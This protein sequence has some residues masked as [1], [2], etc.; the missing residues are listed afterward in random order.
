MTLRH[1]AAAALALG[2]GASALAQAPPGAPPGT[3]NAAP[4]TSGAFTGDDSL[5]AGNAG[6]MSGEI[7]TGFQSIIYKRI[8]VSEAS[9]LWGITGNGTFVDSARD[10]EDLEWFFTVDPFVASLATATPT[11]GTVAN[12]T[13][14]VAGSIYRG[15]GYRGGTSENHDL[16]LS[17]IDG[18]R[19]VLDPGEYYVSVWYDAG[20]AS[21]LWEWTELSTT[22]TFSDIFW[23]SSLHQVGEFDLIA[24]QNTGGGLQMQTGDLAF[25]VW[26]TPVNNCPADLTG[27]GVVDGADLGALLGDWGGSASDLTGD[28][29]V[30]GADLGALLGAWGACA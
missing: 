5:Y 18:V 22:V 29:V 2:W 9:I 20:P 6:F 10:P 12:E 14:T 19:F 17:P 26:M 4:S 3:Y 23:R 15:T 27:D 16:L 1:A 30:D 7:G 11:V 13:L 28:G 24:G 25:D 21:S 8:S